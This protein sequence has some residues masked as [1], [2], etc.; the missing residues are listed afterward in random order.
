MVYFGLD[1]RK[2]SGQQWAAFDLA[3]GRT[4][5]LRD[6]TASS[7]G[8]IFAETYTF[9]HWQCVGASLDVQFPARTSLYV[10]EPDRGTLL[11]VVTIKEKFPYQANFPLALA[12][13]GHSSSSLNRTAYVAVLLVGRTTTESAVRLYAANLYT[14]E[15]G[16]IPWSGG[17]PVALLV[18]PRTG[19]LLVVVSSAANTVIYN[20]DPLTGR[21]FIWLAFGGAAVQPGCQ[22]VHNAGMLWYLGCDTLYTI[23]LDRAQVVS[24]TPVQARAFASFCMLINTTFFPPPPPFKQPFLLRLLTRA[25]S[26]RPATSWAA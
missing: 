3:H 13:D 12:V 19:S 11:H 8:M 18:H 23:D 1:T 4:T 7:S 14:G 15:L 2:W 9:Q 16:V 26:W 17:R 25:C 5:L 10:L 6:M 22:T 24:A 20:V 21:A